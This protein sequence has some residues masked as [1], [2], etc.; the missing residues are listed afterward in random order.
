MTNE[1]PDIAIDLLEIDQELGT[2]D[3]RF[4][5]EEISAYAALLGDASPWFRAGEGVETVRVHPMMLANDY[6]SLLRKHYQTPGLVLTQTEH[7]YARPIMA[8]QR[9]QTSGKVV[10]KGLRSGREYVIVETWTVDENGSEVSRM[11][12][13]ALLNM[14]KRSGG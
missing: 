9:L 7:V 13:T 4:T 1:L 12:T 8:D 3:H 10:D 2:I 6:S 14:E 11:I 5:S